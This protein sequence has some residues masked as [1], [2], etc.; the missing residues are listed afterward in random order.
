MRIVQ[1]KYARTKKG[2][3]LIECNY[4][5]D[6]VDQQIEGLIREHNKKKFERVNPSDDVM[7]ILLSEYLWL[8]KRDAERFV[9]FNDKFY[10]IGIDIGGYHK[11][12]MK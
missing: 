4:L 9:A 12:K 8:E 2:A 5:T 10:K 3:D 1:R 7:E 11:S 6:Q